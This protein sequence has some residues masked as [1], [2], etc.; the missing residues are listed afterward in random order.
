MCICIFG[1]SVRYTA[2]LI[3]KPQLPILVRNRNRYVR[4]I[5]RNTETGPIPKTNRFGLVFTETDRSPIHYQSGCLLMSDFGE[6]PLPIGL[7]IDVGFW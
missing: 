5:N 1:S 4:L 6:N 7:P 3:P 2:K